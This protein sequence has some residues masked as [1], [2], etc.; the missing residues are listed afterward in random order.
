MRSFFSQIPEKL[1]FIAFAAVP[2]CSSAQKTNNDFILTPAAHIG[3]VIAHHGSIQYLVNGHTFATELNFAIPTHGEKKWERIYHY[4]EIGFTF[5]YLNLANPKELGNGYSLYPF[6]NFNLT[7]GQRFRLKFRI[8]QSLGYL[9]KKFDRLE[10]HKNTTIGSHFNGFVNLRLNAT[11]QLSSNLRLETGIGLTHFSN[12]A[13]DLPNQGINIPTFSLGLGYHFHTQNIKLTPDT[14]SIPKNRT[15]FIVYAN[16]G[17]CSIDPP[18]SRKYPAYVTSF[19]IE[20]MHGN[21]NRWNGGIEFAYNASNVAY[22][23]SDTIIKLDS[24]LQNLQMGIKGGY[25]LGV[26]KLIIP[27]EMGIYLYSKNP[28]GHYFHRIGLRY[29]LNEHWIACLTLRTHWANAEFF[30]WGVGYCFSKK[31]KGPFRTTGP[32]F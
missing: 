3:F 9:S 2:L 13:M 29:Q 7:H 25:A 5:V 32:S 16:A 30:E 21:K 12:G 6:I 10:N 20:R 31:K 14:F 18:G 26:G 15:R 17:L 23:N 27:I 8:A 11:I 22:Y 28:I 4:P 19:N 24:D 1:L